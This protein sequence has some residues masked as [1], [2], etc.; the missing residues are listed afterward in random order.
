MRLREFT[1]VSIAGVLSGAAAG[2][3]TPSSPSTPV[4]PTT[5]TITIVGQN[6][7]QAFSPNPASLGGRMVVFRNTDSIVH[8]V[9]LNDSTVDTGEI[10]PVRHQPRGGDAGRRHQLPLPASIPG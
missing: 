2:S 7:T 3:S 5:A 6:G 8:R 10:A 4:T 1:L 9:V